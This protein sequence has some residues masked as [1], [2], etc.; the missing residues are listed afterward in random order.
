MF[1]LH[2]NKRIIVK[3]TI[4]GNSSRLTEGIDIGVTILDIEN[5]D[6]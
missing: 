5:R 4:N 6:Y 3:Y 1:H 2:E